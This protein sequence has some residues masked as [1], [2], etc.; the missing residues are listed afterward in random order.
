MTNLEFTP[1]SYSAL[2]T[3][4]LIDTTGGNGVDGDGNGDNGD[5]KMVCG[6][7]E[8]IKFKVNKKRERT[9]IFNFFNF[10]LRLIWL[11]TIYTNYSH[12]CEL[13]NYA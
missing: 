9:K 2:L 8:T 10:F 7:R 6:T 3:T 1:W 13:Y 12:L 11:G 4:L 5:L